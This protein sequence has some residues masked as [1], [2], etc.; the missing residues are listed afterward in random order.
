MSTLDHGAAV[1]QKHGISRSP[2]WSHVRA[3]H[4]ARQPA[5]VC[6]K[7]GMSPPT[8]QVHHIFP[9]H[10]CILLGRPDLELDPRNL[11]TL[12]ET[13]NGNPAA[14]HHLLIGH[15]NSFESSNLAV[16]HDALRTFHG[17]LAATIRADKRWIAEVAARLKPFDQMTDHEK[18]AFRKR[19]NARLPRTGA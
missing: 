14:N 3:A 7:P 8:L 6:C 5:C 2:L 19:M 16:Q 4:L 1:A 15:L 11:I 10:F 12:C 18:T 9:F 13:G 17:Q